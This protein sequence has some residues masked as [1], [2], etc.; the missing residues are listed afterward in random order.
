MYRA[1]RAK[2]PPERFL[3][4]PGENALF[5]EKNAKA[6]D[7]RARDNAGGGREAEGSIN[8]GRTGSGARVR[9]IASLENA[10]FH[11][12]D[13][14]RESARARTTPGPP[15]LP[16]SLLLPPSSLASFYGSRLIGRLII[17]A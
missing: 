15:S 12:G 6:S 3:A 10:R 7:R 2:E 14:S 11:D 5:D 17:G 4:S 9:E 1:L 13:S 16:P 8:G